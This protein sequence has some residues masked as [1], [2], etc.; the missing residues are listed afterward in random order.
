[1]VREVSNVRVLFTAA[2]TPAHFHVQ[3]PL[4]SA[5]KDAGH[6]VAFAAGP[7]VVAGIERAGFTAFAVGPPDL[8]PRSATPADPAELVPW[9]WEELYVGPP[10][11]ERLADLAALCDRWQPDLIARENAELAG[12]VAAEA[13]GIPH[14]VVQNGNIAVVWQLRRQRLRER[15]DAL[16]AAQGLAPDP[17]LLMLW[18]YLLLLPVPLSFHDPALRLPPTAHF[19]RPRTFDR[20]G[21]DPV[22]DWLGA[23]PPQPTVYMTLG[24]VF[25]TRHDLFETVIAA[26]RDEPVNLIVTVGR[27]QDPNQFGPQ[28]GNVHIE[29]YIPHSDLLSRCDVM[30]NMAGMNSV[31]TA[32]EHAVPLVLLPLVAEHR[33][34]AERCA[35][36]GMGLVLDAGDMRPNDVQTAVRRVL[37]DPTY[38][39]NARRV[40]DELETMPGPEHAAQLLEQLYAH[41]APVTETK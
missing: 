40:R 21:D 29:R 30:I 13:R 1:L 27:D 9:V 38:R 2:N 39:E 37:A 36:L 35:A 7:N 24:T 34:N 4:A 14:A 32:F 41:N 11:A 12:C 22:P 33:F 8:W 20:T 10:A 23:L 5:V 25:N 6:E 19:I 15:L 16:R 17:D 3:I 28:P 18:R 31:R 26:L